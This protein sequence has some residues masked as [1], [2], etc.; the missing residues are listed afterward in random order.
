MPRLDDIFAF[1]S[2]TFLNKIDVGMKSGWFCIDFYADIHTV[3]KIVRNL[4]Q[5]TIQI[6][7]KIQEVCQEATKISHGSYGNNNLLHFKILLKK[8]FVCIEN[9]LLTKNDAF[10]LLS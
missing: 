5:L 1:F 6:Y 3:R 8:L 2:K 10:D 4:N 7:P 9:G